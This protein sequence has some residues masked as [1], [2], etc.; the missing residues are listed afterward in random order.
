MKIIDLLFLTIEKKLEYKMNQEDMF[1]KREFTAYFS[2]NDLK[3][4]KREYANDSDLNGIYLKG[5][6]VIPDISYYL[7][8]GNELNEL[9][10]NMELQLDRASWKEE[11]VSREQIWKEDPN[12]KI[13]DERLEKIKNNS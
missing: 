12:A 3:I 8:K 11:F 2:V 13:I 5:K 7:L 4:E 1:L 10:E 6:R 9:P